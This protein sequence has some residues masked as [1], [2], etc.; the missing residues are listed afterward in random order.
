MLALE[1]LVKYP[2]TREARLYLQQRRITLAELEKPELREAIELAKKRILTALRGNSNYESSQTPSDELHLLSYPIAIAILSYLKDPLLTSRFAV[3][4][5]RRIGASLRKEPEEKLIQIARST[6]GWNIRR[7]R[8][9]IGERLYTI[10][11]HFTDYL[12]AKSP[13][14][15]FWRL[16]NRVLLNGYV[17]LQKHE[18]ARL[19]EEEVRNRIIEKIE[20]ERLE[21]VPSILEQAA[22]EIAKEFT[23]V[24]SRLKLDERAKA[25]SKDSSLFPPCILKLFEDAMK[26]SNLP[27]MARF[28]LATF[29][30]NIGFSIDEVVDI[31]RR[32]PDFR[33]DITRYQ[34]EHL[35][36]LRGSRT[37]YS[38]PSCDTLRTFGLCPHPPDPLCERVRHPLI[39]YYM[40]AR[41]VSNAKRK[42]S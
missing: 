16:V 5:A 26:G 36:G 34:V 20:S 30:L 17:L 27:H 24:K 4:E 42:K 33:E 38:P 9:I 14:D 22:I 6:F 39:Y 31:F 40:R 11:I 25:E 3:A 7:V 35:A 29:L 41:G 32:M 8:V 1:D 28:T 37:K 21:N 15:P 12:R 18:L 19:M 13:R 10:A 23:D 2:F